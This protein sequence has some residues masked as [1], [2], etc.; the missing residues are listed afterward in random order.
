MGRYG[1]WGEETALAGI[2]RD[3]G[4]F[5]SCGVIYLCHQLNFVCAHGHEIS[6][7][8]LSP[9]FSTVRRKSGRLIVSLIRFKRCK[10]SQAMSW[11]S[12]G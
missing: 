7:L 8:D 5:G 1:I 2:L 9:V 3:F 4:G 11:R 6:A 10:I 12:K